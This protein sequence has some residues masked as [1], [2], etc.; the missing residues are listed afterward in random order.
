MCV[1]FPAAVT[2]SFDHDLGLIRAIR[3]TAHTRAARFP[4]SAV[5]VLSDTAKR[6]AISDFLDSG[7]SRNTSLF[8]I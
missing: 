1:A 6:I 7:F 3:A 8:D 4:G 5:S 2:R